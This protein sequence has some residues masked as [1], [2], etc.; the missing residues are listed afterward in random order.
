MAEVLFHRSSGQQL[1][2]LR[3]DAHLKTVNREATAA[4]LIHSNLVKFN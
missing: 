4:V 1:G 3:S 2:G